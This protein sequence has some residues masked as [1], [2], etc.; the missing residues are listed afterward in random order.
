MNPTLWRSCSCRRPGLPR[1]TTSRSS[2][3]ADSPRRKA[4]R[5]TP[6][7]R[8][9]V[10]GLGGGGRLCRGLGGDRLVCCLLGLGETARARAV[11]DHGVGGIVEERDAVDLC[12][13]LEPELVT[14]L[15]PADVD[16]DVLGDRRRQGLD[17][18][19]AGDLLHDAADLGARRLADE[20]HDDCR[21]DRL[22]EPYLV[23]VDVRDRASD[24]CC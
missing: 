15:E 14:E 11:R 13:V 17:V 21:L 22:V 16:L 5:A 2:V 9:G 7:L 10:S 4:A 12:D 8:D 1:P 18:E 3:E 23:E 24:G 20:L 19:L 6:R